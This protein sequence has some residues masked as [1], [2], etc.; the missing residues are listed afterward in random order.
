MTKLMK[1]LQVGKNGVNATLMSGD[2]RSGA[3]QH[4]IDASSPRGAHGH[5]GKGGPWGGHA[6]PI[7]TMVGV[8]VIV[9]VLFG[10]RMH[11]R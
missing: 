11:D 2:A 8:A 10:W 3:L 5:G 6:A 4:A 9:V 7:V 1:G